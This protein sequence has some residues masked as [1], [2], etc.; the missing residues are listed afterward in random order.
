MNRVL[1]IFML[2]AFAWH[3]PGQA[4]YSEDPDSVLAEW[5]EAQEWEG[6]IL[7]PD[8]AMEWLTDHDT[9]TGERVFERPSSN[10][11][12]TFGVPMGAE[13]GKWISDSGGFVSPL[14]FKYRIKIS[15]DR[16]WEY[17]MQTNQVA[18]DS[19][20]IWPRSGLPDHLSQSF[21]IRPGAI[22]EEILVGD[23][24]I[25]SGFGAVAG[26]GAVFSVSLGNPGSLSR[27]GKGL[28]P[29]S[30]STDGRFLSG[31]AGNMRIGS[32][33]LQMYGSGKDRLEETVTGFGLKRSFPGAEAGL[34]GMRVA[35]R[36]APEVSE[37]WTSLWQ[38]DSGRFSRLG[39]W[40]QTRVPVG[41]L[42]GELG[43]SP[44]GG[45]AWIAGFRW[46]ETHGFSFVVRYVGCSPGYPVTYSLFQSGNSLVREG[47]KIVASYRY[48]PGRLVE[49]LGC[50]E[51]GLSDYPGANPRFQNYSTRAS[52]QW[53]Y[54]SK[55][56]WSCIGTIQLDFLESGGA[57]P[58]RLSWKMAFDSNPGQSGQLRFRAGIRRQIKGFGSVLSDGTT[59][60]C[61]MTMASVGKRILATCGFRIFSVDT[62][63]DPLYIYEP[64]V[65]YGF[66]APVLTGSGTGWFAVVRWRITE[67]FDLE[68]KVG[69][70]AY[71]DLKHLT[72][73]T[74]GGFSGKLQVSWQAN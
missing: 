39:I 12:L 48:A 35:R 7:H 34:T 61:S 37:G 1:L 16:R 6:V 47:R 54:V 27:S 62:G 10:H 23:F 26:S 17:R 30:G 51:I 20:L 25:S 44:G 65:R 69:R 9:M 3:L 31:M 59:A 8:I 15:E 66:S 70:T 18:G 68:C 28:R 33:E 4:I 74:P 71:S 73:G 63:G 43:W 52:Q 5:L 42:F 21:M 38:P 64:D 40:G 14:S 67:N 24:Q 22:F 72:S 19:C 58:C 32:F 53:K 46:F 41:L 55:D 57:V 2:L 29:Y 36:F 13:L 49:V 56:K 60:D 50:M 11:L 45:Y